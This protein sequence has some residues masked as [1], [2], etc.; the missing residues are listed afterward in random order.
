MQLIIVESPTKARTLSRFLQGTYTVEATM[1]H[2][3]DLP[4]AELGVD[5]EQ[6][7]LPRYVIPRDKAKRVGELK[8]IA[9]KADSVILATDPDREGEAIAWHVSQI[10]KLDTRKK[11]LDKEARKL[12][13]EKNQSSNIQSQNLASSFQRL[14]SM[15][16]IV[17]HEITETAIKEALSH[18]REIDLKLVDAQQARRVL[19]RL[20]GYKLSPLLWKKLSKR[21]LSAGRVQSVA[22]RLIVERE[23]EIETF[24]SQEFWTIEGT[25]MCHPSG[26]GDSSSIVAQLTSKDGVKYEETLVFELFDGKY[27]T[28][29]TTIPTHDAA[30]AII[31]DSNA[32]YIVSAVETKEIRR[33]PGPPYT[34]STLQQ[35]AGRKLYFSSKKTMQLAQKLYEEG[36][37]TYHRTDSVNL[38]EKFIEEARRY[39]SRNFGAAYVPDVPRKFQTKSKVAQEA[40]EA[41]RPTDVNLTN[42]AT[43]SNSE[44]N[45]DHH[46]LYELIWKRAI[47]SQA[48]E[49]VFDSTTVGIKSANAYQFELQ[50]SVITFD[51]FLRVMGRDADEIVIPKVAVGESVNLSE[52]TPIQHFTSPPPRYTEAS[53]VKTLEEKDIGRPSTYA[54]IITTIQD[55]QYVIREE[56]KLVPTELGKNVTDFLVQYFPAILDLPFTAK[57]EN[58]LDAIANGEKKWQPVISDFYKPFARDLAT[59]Y[60]VAEK[61]AVPVEELGEPCP[62]CGHPLVIRVG[63]YGKFVACS[64]FPACK[65]TRQFLEKID[66]KCPR[67]GGDMVVKK[68]RKGKTFYGC[69]NYPTCNFA[70]WKKEDIK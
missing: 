10:L 63:R 12:K 14:S 27:T 41:I 8:D 54:P 21:W 3:R 52:A 49:A 24:K 53:L 9:A 40:H 22:V 18:A 42:V 69:G 28:T 31:H 7:F 45:R 35:D 11:K 48:K 46:R 23:R 60:D 37:I 57:L 58:D 20:V 25:F 16:R 1:G 36:H 13:I 5:V 38:A 50:G 15:K 70:A 43:L 26:G 34:T 6:N 33:N 61:V 65:Y 56:K 51:G 44:F 32:P 62:T 68:S 30:G 2:V 29:K 39:L 4:K 59:T 47:A 66:I 67:C 19:D 55:R 17:F 64:T